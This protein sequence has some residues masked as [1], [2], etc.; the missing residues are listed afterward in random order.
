MF[1]FTKKL[2]VSDLKG[3]TNTEKE[4]KKEAREDVVKPA[5]ETE[6]VLKER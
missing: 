3:G 5:N 4:E 6:T 2:K 1:F